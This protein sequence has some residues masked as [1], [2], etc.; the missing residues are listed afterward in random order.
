MPKLQRSG[1]LHRPLIDHQ[2][3][4]HIPSHPIPSHPVASFSWQCE[5]WRMDDGCH[6]D[7]GWMDGVRWTVDT[8]LEF[9]NVWDSFGPVG[10]EQHT[11]CDV[12][13]SHH[14][15]AR[16]RNNRPQDGTRQAWTLCWKDC[17]LWKPRLLLTTQVRLPSS[18]HHDASHKLSPPPPSSPSPPPTSPSLVD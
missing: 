3:C 12:C 10:S 8:C 6:D 18:S 7:D 14:R 15:L 13:C 17:P 1:K 11:D 9:V 5:Y 16:R 2:A 4:H